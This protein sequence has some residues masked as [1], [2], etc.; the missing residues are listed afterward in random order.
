MFGCLILV[1]LITAFSKDFFDL[2]E[3]Y[4]STIKVGDGRELQVIGIGTVE[5]QIKSK[6]KVS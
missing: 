3:P 4:D 2:I 1:P 5:L 6:N